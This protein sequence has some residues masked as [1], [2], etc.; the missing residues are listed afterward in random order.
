MRRTMLLL[1][2]MVLTLLVASGVALAVT[3]IGD[4]GPNNIVGT[5]REDSLL[6]RGGHDL[7]N[8]KGGN[9]NVLGGAGHRDF[10]QT[11]VC[12]RWA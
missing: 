2:A 3:R 9:D 11:Q 12:L 7:V 10:S 5:N 6:G 4:D 1:S 8:G